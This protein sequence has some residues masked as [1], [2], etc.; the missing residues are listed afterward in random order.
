MRQPDVGTIAHL[1]A[2]N[3]RYYGARV[4]DKIKASA[5]RRFAASRYASLHVPAWNAT[6]VSALRS[7]RGPLAR[8]LALNRSAVADADRILAGEYRLFGNVIHS[9]GGFPDWHLDYL[10]GHRF[11][12]RPYP[13]YTIDV[14]RGSD[15]I[16]PWELSRFQFVPSLVSAF[17]ATRDQRYRDAFF[18]TVADWQARNPYLFGVNWMS[19][20]D[21]AIRALNIATG[22]VFL[23][24]RDDKRSGPVR[25]LLWAHIVY[26]QE[27]DLY[28]RKRVINNHQLIA[29]AIH[30]SLLRLFT[31]PTVEAWRAAVGKIVASETARQFHLDGGNFESAFGYH[32][33]VLEALSIAALFEQS[34]ETG[35]LAVLSHDAGDEMRA[36]LRRAFS[37]VSSYTSAWR[38][39]PQIG[40]SS[41]GRVLFHRDYFDWR[42]TDP[43]YLTDLSAVLFPADDPFAVDRAR[44]AQLFPE[45]G[46]G[47]FLNHRYGMVLTALPVCSPAGGHNH[48]DQTSILLRVDRHHVLVD[49][50]TYCYTSDVASR[51]RF[52]SGRSHNVVLV[53]GVEPGHI[54]RQ[55]IFA[56]PEFGGNG[57]H[58]NG[59]ND[60][61]PEFSAYHNG[62]TRI[63]K[64]GTITRRVLCLEDRIEIQDRVDG[65][66]D[67]TIELVFNFHPE[68]DTWVETDELTLT[69]N[70]RQLARMRLSPGWLLSRET[71]AYSASYR[72]RCDC[73]R[74]VF[75]RSASLPIEFATSIRITAQQT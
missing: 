25:H 23:D 66:G 68:I 69:T 60:N 29:A 20:L 67:A 30:L 40:D 15:I 57:I 52:R 50:G 70:G 17:Q 24:D 43:A 16:C 42:P 72:D 74:V 19:G 61:A 34:D 27:R 62:Y 26:L 44:S 71:G 53:A 56:V 1:L 41:D 38:A 22:M 3:G 31:G 36:R 11:P 73:P 8:L 13:V 54:A 4:L 7:D 64:C 28:E 55:G 65:T 32:Q 46:V 12:V 2:V 39:M 49:S 6:C 48:F 10:S 35:S 51:T 59:V 47:T 45:S 33:F 9:R 18:A 21:I 75:S 37:F 63:G 14:D 5:I 58:L